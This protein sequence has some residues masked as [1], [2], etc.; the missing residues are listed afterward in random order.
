M[1]LGDKSPSRPVR[2]L[3]KGNRVPWTGLPDN[4][5]PGLGGSQPSRKGTELRYTKLSTWKVNDVAAADWRSGC[6]R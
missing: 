1:I 4:S 3:C 6:N 5:F 2:A